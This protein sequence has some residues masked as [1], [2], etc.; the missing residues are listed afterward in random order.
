MADRLTCTVEEAA[1]LLGISRTL[2]YRLVKSGKLPS[3]KVGK[4]RLIPVTAVETFIAEQLSS[5]N[6]S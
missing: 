2:A 6:A 1:R 5:A 4:R 3:F